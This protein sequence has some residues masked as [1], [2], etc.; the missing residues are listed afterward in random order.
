MSIRIYEGFESKIA[1]NAILVHVFQS[2]RKMGVGVK[3]WCGMKGGLAIIF[4]PSNDK[5]T[6]YNFKDAKIFVTHLCRMLVF[7]G[8]L[9]AC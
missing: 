5:A 3:S 1:K 6:K 8:K 2:S 7:M 9:S 4:N